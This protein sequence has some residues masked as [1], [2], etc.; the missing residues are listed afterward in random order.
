MVGRVVAL[1]QRSDRSCGAAADDSVRG[2]VAR[3]NGVG[4][5]D[6]MLADAYPGQHACAFANPDSILDDDGAFREN[7]AQGR[8]SVDVLVIGSAVCMVSDVDTTRDQYMVAYLYA[9]D[10]T[11]VAIVVD[12]DSVPD[13]YLRR[14][15][16]TQMPVK[17]LETQSRE[18]VEGATNSDVPAADNHPRTPDHRTGPTNGEAATMHLTHHGI[19]GARQTPDDSEQKLEH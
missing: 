4:A 5:D 11:D 12:T 1:N 7:L 16:A 8:R 17:D 19:E 18:A 13:Y 9:I 15:T 2:D 3:H 14:E 6:R 10:A